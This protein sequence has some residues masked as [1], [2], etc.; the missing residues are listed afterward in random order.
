VFDIGF[1]ELLLIGIIG[2]LVL[3]P[4]RLPRAIRTGSLWLGRLRR[5]FS[6]IK[7]EVNRELG[8]DEIR[9]QLHNESI[10]SD[11]KKSRE[12]LENTSAALRQPGQA[13]FKSA[14]QPSVAATDQSPRDATDSDAQNTP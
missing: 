7:A 10:M 14:A 5:Q 9:A 8:T 11:L 12:A 3:G 2:L 6:E 13:A 4:E 1:T